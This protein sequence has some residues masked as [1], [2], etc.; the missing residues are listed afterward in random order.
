M[1]RRGARLPTLGFG[2]LLAVALS[3]CAAEPGPTVT[4]PSP[5]ASTPPCDRDAED[6]WGLFATVTDAAGEPIEGAVVEV[7][8]GDFFGN[9]RTT[10]QGDFRAPCVWGVFEVSVGHLE[11]N[12][13]SRTVAVDPGE[14]REITFE[15]E[16]LER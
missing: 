14:R 16:P 10:A 11:Y 6:A 1:R 8:S 9:A 12:A 15:L 13:A 5:R 3:A 4:S 2:T 7:L